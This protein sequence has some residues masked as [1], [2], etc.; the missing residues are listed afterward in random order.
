MAQGVS[1]SGV[2]TLPRRKTQRDLEASLSL[3]IAGVGILAV[4]L[5]LLLIGWLHLTGFSAAGAMLQD[6]ILGTAQVF[7]LIGA[8]F[9]VINWSLLRR[10]P[11]PS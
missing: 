11:H 9:A 10:V 5:G 8:L 4:W 6:V 2:F 3:L 7:V 1:E